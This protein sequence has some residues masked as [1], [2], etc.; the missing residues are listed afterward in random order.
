LWVLRD[1]PNG[2]YS[3]FNPN[4]TCRHHKPPPAPAPAAKH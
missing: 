3:P 2:A 4:V 1:N